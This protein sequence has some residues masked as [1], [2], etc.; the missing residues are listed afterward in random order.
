MY[1]RHPTLVYHL[2]GRMTPISHR[3]HQCPL[4]SPPCRRAPPQPSSDFHPICTCSGIPQ[5][6]T[7]LSQLFSISRTFLWYLR[8]FLTSY[9]T[10]TPGIVL[11]IGHVLFFIL[12]LFS[13]F[14]LSL[15]PFVPVMHNYSHTSIITH[16]IYVLPLHVVIHSQRNSNALPMLT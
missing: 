2:T 14:K 9:L 1:L 15:P 11:I 16:Y 6:S 10:G 8:C 5:H 7:T 3:Y 13:P 12:Q 4:P